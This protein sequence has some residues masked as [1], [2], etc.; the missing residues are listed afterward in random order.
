MSHIVPM[1]WM[2]VQGKFILFVENL[3]EA[4]FNQAVELSKSSSCKKR[5]K[6]AINFHQN[7]IFDG[8]LNAATV[9]SE[10]EKNRVEGED[11]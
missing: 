9:K 5:N 2:C 4:S 3:F 1:F 7:S 10:R 6:Q 8:R 11:V